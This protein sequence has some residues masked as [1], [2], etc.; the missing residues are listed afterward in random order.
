MAADPA[1]PNKP[2]R[3]GVA[4]ILA[5]A[6][7]SQAG[8]R[9]AWQYEAAFREELLLLVLLVPAACWL[10]QSGVQI[11]VLLASCFVVL[12]TE[13]LNSAIEAVVDLASPDMHSLAGRAKDMG[14][15]A[16]F[17]ALLQVVVVW[18]LVAWQRFI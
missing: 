7:Y 18:A 13:L 1:T 15:A 8:L 9:Q 12:I 6:G 14:S 10:G 11:A 16:V 17:M 4:R 5:A 3:K 2:G